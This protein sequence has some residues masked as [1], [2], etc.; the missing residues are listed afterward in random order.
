MWPV[1][2]SCHWVSLCPA[3]AWHGEGPVAGKPWRVWP[4]GSQETGVSPRDAIH[5]WSQGSA[6]GP[7]LT[8]KSTL[9]F[10]TKGW[11]RAD[12]IELLSGRLGAPV[13]RLSGAQN[14]PALFLLS[15]WFLGRSPSNSGG[16]LPSRH[17]AAGPRGAGTSVFPEHFHIRQPTSPSQQVHS[18]CR[19]H[20]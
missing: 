12:S 1:V 15:R 19:S 7:V 13:R 20:R 16:T 4:A 10:G 17:P 5:S 9:G 14:G 2:S 11:S 3:A 18:G 6:E 8:A